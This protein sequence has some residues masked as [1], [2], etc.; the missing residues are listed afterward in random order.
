MMKS[1]LCTLLACLALS[2]VASSVLAGGLISGY[3]L[4]ALVERTAPATPA[5]G[6][7]HL[8]AAE[9]GTL[10]YL[11]DSALDLEIG[12]GGGGFTIFI[13]AA[14]MTPAPSD[15]VI[16]GF[17]TLAT[18]GMPVLA[19]D[20]ATNEDIL[21]QGVVM[22]AAYVSGDDLTIELVWTAN[23]T[24]QSVEW[25]VEIAA[26]AGQDIDGAAPSFDTAIAHDATSNGTQG[27]YT[28][29]TTTSANALVD[30]IAAGELFTMRITRDAASDASTVDSYLIG[31]RISQ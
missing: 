8:Y 27:I 23:G 3:D 22:P 5:A 19:F 28:T 10:H 15:S 29:T 4:F 12:S 17:T 26:L 21:A 20:G 2:L 30:A 24:S 1:N 6:I 25:D 14:S 18:S 7:G 9:D 13:P 11:N 16:P 31:V